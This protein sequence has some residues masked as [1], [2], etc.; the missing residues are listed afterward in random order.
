MMIISLRVLIDLWFNWVVTFCS[1]IGSIIWVGLG[2][3]VVEILHG[4]VGA[5]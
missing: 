1:G 5:S 2:W 3:W 4:V